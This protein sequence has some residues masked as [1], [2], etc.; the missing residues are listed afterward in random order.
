MSRLPKHAKS[1][2]FDPLADWSAFAGRYLDMT[3]LHIVMKNY[4]LRACGTSMILHPS[5]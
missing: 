4:P 3:P 5:P 2:S 1:F